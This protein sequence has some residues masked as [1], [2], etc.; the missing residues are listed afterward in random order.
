MSNVPV[1]MDA[2]AIELIFAP[3]N[4]RRAADL[5]LTM[6]AHAAIGL[7]RVARWDSTAITW[8]A[9][10]AAQAGPVVA[11]TLEHPVEASFPG[12]DRIETWLS[13]PIAVMAA[14]SVRQG[15][16]WGPAVSIAGTG[17]RIEMQA[18]I[19]PTRPVEAVRL[20]LTTTATGPQQITLISFLAVDGPARALRDRRRL[21]WDAAWP[22]LLRPLAERGPPVF[23]RGLLFEV[24]DLPRLRARRHQPGFAQHWA[25]LRAAAHRIATRPPEDR[26]GLT[27]PW[28]DARYQPSDRIEKDFFFHDPLCVAV[29]G[30]IDED[31]VLLDWAAR[32]LLALV[33]C[34]YWA[35]GEERRVGSTWTQR[36]FLAEMAA[37]A[38]ALLYDWIG[39]HLTDVGRE[40][41]LRTMWDKGLAQIEGDLMQHEYCW[42]INQGPWFC[43]ARILVGLLL[44]RSWPRMGGYVDRAAADMR[45]ML[46]NY[47]QADGGIDEGVGYFVMTAG[48]VL[49]AALAW[50]KARGRDAKDLMPQAMARSGDYLSVLS[51]LRPG[52]VMLEGDNSSPTVLGD[53]V[54]LLAAL[55]PETAWAKLLPAMLGR[56][57]PDIYFAQ[58]LPHGE[59]TFCLAPEVRHAPSCLV[60]VFGTLPMSG[61]LT[62]RRPLASGEVRVH[63]AG[64]KAHASHT[65]HDKGGIT[66]ELEG[67]PLLID[68][69][70]V[71]YDDAGGLQLK[72][73]RAHNVLTPVAPDGLFPDQ[74]LPQ[75]PVIPMG[76][77]DACRLIARIDLAHVWREWMTACERRLD[78]PCPERLTII[79]RATLRIPGCVAFHLQSHVPWRIDGPTASI[80]R[81]TVRMPWAARIAC[82]EDLY[83]HA[84]RPVYRLTA[85]SETGS[86]FE[87]STTMDINP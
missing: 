12:H 30:L 53:G 70:M 5:P 31:P 73:S 41:A 75:E 67:E 18:P 81:L 4:D 50:A 8:D 80:G 42:H 36:C 78:S 76:L 79:D 61:H 15:G 10:P 59:L 85:W 55:Y 86:A 34:Q 40:L 23:A 35:M 44:E 37:S 74:L 82:V 14:L 72:R 24:G 46:D 2:S 83:D 71:R 51:A 65:H 26:I 39:S 17:R 29:V 49:P 87:L 32:A 28:S 60:P 20:E 7:N 68:R 84:F 6:V 66:L 1:L 56:A 38:A 54:A 48:T 3:W 22:G 77:G 13:V 63:F 16:A 45:T 19:D 57:K 69:G 62:S 27:V 43:R 52:E 11:A 64:A 25:M 9:A 21:T 47:V 33:H 58:Y